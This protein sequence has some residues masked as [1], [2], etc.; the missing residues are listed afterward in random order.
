M[1][2][3]KQNLPIHAKLIRP[4]FDEFKNRH[5]ELNIAKYIAEAVRS[6]EV[7]HTNN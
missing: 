7:D 1:I 5:L 4:K 3:E 6:R 2:C